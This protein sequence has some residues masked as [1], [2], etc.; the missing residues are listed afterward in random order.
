MVRVIQVTPEKAS[1]KVKDLYAAIQK[2]MGRIPNIFL[3]MGNSPAVLEGYLSFSEAANHTS[4]SPQIREQIALTVSQS[5]NCQYCLSAHSVLSKGAGLSDNDILKA[6]QAQ[7]QDSKTQAILKFTKQAVD[8]RGNIKNQD[9]AA[10]KA[11][12]V[13]DTELVE[14]VMIISLNMFTNYF[15]HITDTAIDFPEAPALK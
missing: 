4:L 9:V 8:S 13:S 14:I 2:K 10:I 5:N 6:R 3:N 12:G 15:N 11:S 1:S 7:A